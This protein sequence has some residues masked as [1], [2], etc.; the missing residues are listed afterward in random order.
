MKAKQFLDDAHRHGHRGPIMLKRWAIKLNTDRRRT[1]AD[2]VSVYTLDEA[3][4]M[5]EGE[6]ADGQRRLPV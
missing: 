4:A 3:I 5:E 2:F 1:P 6:D